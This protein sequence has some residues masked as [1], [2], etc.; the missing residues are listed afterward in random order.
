[1][2][3]HVRELLKS[4]ARNFIRDEVDCDSEKGDYI[5]SM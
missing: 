2:N 3:M 4:E 1:M 5:K